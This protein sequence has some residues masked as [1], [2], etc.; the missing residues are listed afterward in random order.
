[1]QIFSSDFF[2]AMN[3]QSVKDVVRFLGEYS[4]NLGKDCDFGPGLDRTA[5]LLERIHGED[6][7][8]RKSVN[9]KSGSGFDI[10]S[11]RNIQHTS[12]I[13]KVKAAKPEIPFIENFNDDLKS[14]LSYY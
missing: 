10:L 9:N 6:P 2:R 5:M 7:E 12:V 4:V 3:V 1:M 13:S 14:F 11:Y 8:D